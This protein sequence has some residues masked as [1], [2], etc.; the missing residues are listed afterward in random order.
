M[1]DVQIVLRDQT[2]NV[3]SYEAAS[4]NHSGAEAEGESAAWW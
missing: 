3:W 4:Q 1:M 2:V